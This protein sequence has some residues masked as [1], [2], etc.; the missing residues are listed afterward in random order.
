MT[1]W[2]SALVPG[3][4][5]EVVMV[6]PE[7]AQQFLNDIEKQRNASNVRTERYTL[8]M[9]SG[10]WPFTGD[11]MRF[12]T[13]GNFMDGQHRCR[14]IVESGQAQP[15]LI[16]RGLPA[17]VMQQLDIGFKRTFANLLQIAEIGNAS[18]VAAVTRAHF[19]WANELYGEKS[20]A[21]VE[22]AARH[23]VDPTHAELWQHFARHGQNIELA[24]R[25]GAR[26]TATFAPRRISKTVVALSWMIM[27]EIDPFRRDAFWGQV[28][29]DIPFT[30]NRSDY[31]PAV[32]QDRLRRGL[33]VHETPAPAWTML[34]MIIRCWNSWIAGRKQG[35]IR[36][37]YAPEPRFLPQ[38]IDPATWVP[39]DDDDEETL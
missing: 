21:R 13:K 2:E 14:A 18:L 16:I 11:P 35:A 27:T 25:E 9:D 36:P 5:F 28:A 37:P 39:S 7:L 6:T 38:P 8:D 24:A 4:T 31:A 15:V 10:N 34:A 20:I 19:H 32:L 29:G 1:T 12:D 23:G 26:L 30:S 17:Q 22:N 3:V 33:G